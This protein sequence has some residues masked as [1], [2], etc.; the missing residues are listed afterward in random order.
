M[1][2]STLQL[3]CL[4]LYTLEVAMNSFKSDYGTPPMRESKYKSKYL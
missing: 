3:V 1:D 2:A 4:N